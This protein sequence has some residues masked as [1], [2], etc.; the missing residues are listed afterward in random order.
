MLTFVH[1]GSHYST[2]NAI[3]ERGF[4]VMSNVHTKKIK[5]RLFVKQCGANMIISFNGVSYQDFPNRPNAES[6]EKGETWWGFV[7]NL[8][9]F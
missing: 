4:S 5:S 2:G 3:S 1:V 9:V 6:L 8:H 7:D